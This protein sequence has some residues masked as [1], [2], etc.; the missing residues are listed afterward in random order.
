[1]MPG[2]RA[3]VKPG[4]EKYKRKQTKYNMQG[5]LKNSSRGFE[6]QKE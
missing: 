3:E 1:M 6:E 5:C 2:G 4:E